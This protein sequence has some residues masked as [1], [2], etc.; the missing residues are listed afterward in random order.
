MTR[1]ATLT[2][3]AALLTVAAVTTASSAVAKPIDRGTFHD[4]FSV[5]LTDFCAV[6]GLD[7]TVD[8][9]IDGRFSVRSQGGDQLAYYYEL[10]KGTYTY[11]NPDND[12]YLTEVFHV[13]DK[14]LRVTD[15]GDGTL[16]ILLFVTGNSTVSG[17]D[18]KAISR[19]P[20]QSRWE[21]LIDH[22]GTPQDPSDDEFL[23]FLGDVKESTG[24]TDDFCAAAVPALT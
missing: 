17:M 23:E 16:T 18:G 22:G 10:Q 19:N 6:A 9:V 21:I 8:G 14:D 1:L 7:I 20:G 3:T 12:Q 13:I 2:A 5:V 24:R 11:T 15:N 4:E